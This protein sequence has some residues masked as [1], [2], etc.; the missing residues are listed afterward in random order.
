MKW[1]CTV[2]GYVHEGP[3]APAECPICHVGADK[4]KEFRET[5]LYLDFTMGVNLT[6]Q[7]A[8]D[9]VAMWPLDVCV[10]WVRVYQ[11]EGSKLTDRTTVV[12]PKPDKTQNKK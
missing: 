5:E 1:V 9:E 6:E 8:I 4:F 11:R 2:C 7:E 12:A 10:D 3:E